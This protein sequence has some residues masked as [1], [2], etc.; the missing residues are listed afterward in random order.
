MKD[1]FK[2]IAQQPQM[3]QGILIHEVSRSPQ[4]VVLLW[5]SDQSD[6]ETST[7]QDTT[8]TADKLPCPR[9]DSNPHF[10]QASVRKPRGHWDRQMKVSAYI[11]L[12]N[13]MQTFFA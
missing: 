8:L 4:S 2:I 5:T 10:Q 7:R 1:F 3:G 9:W 12:L 6:A 13:E 11:K